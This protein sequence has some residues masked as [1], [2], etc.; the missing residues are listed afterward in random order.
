MYEH[1]WQRICDLYLFDKSKLNNLTCS[2]V[3][4]VIIF[5]FHFLSF[6]FFIF[7]RCRSI[8]VKYLKSSLTISTGIITTKP[9]RLSIYVWI[10][11]FQWEIWQLKWIM[12]LCLLRGDFLS[13][14]SRFYEVII[15]R[16][17]YAIRGKVMVS[18]KSAPWWILWVYVCPWFV[19][20]PKVFQLCINQFV[21]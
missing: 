8:N 10:L 15:L 20:A 2:C 19:R 16:N 21:V 1:L 11:K 3:M 9:L 17:T 12:K 5:S 13:V 14:Y 4:I 18:P 6:T 7:T